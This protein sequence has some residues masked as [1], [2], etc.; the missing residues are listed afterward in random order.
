MATTAEKRCEVCGNTY[1][2]LIE[3]RMKGAVH[4]FDS[5]ECATHALA[6]RCL[7][8][9]VRIL[10]HG[11]QVDEALFCCAHCARKHGAMG[12]IDRQN[13]HRHAGLHS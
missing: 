11:V 3:V 12:I 2:D 6:P 13:T 9:N 5:F 10:G 7:E 4:H 8:C 1:D